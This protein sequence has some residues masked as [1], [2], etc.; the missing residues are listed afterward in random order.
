[1]SE[2]AQAEKASQAGVQWWLANSS[3][4]NAA[5]APKPTLLR[6]APKPGTQIRRATEKM[7]GPPLFTGAA[8]RSGAIRAKVMI[9][10]AVVAKPT[11]P[12][13]PLHRERFR[14]ARRRRRTSR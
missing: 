14:E 12:K 10:A 4:L 9:G 7:L 8:P 13:P 5:I 11:A 6:A 3:E 1:M 2:A